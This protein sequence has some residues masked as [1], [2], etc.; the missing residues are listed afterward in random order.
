MASEALKNLVKVIAEAVNTG[1]KQ[2][3]DG[4]QVTDLFALIPI[5]SQIPAVIASKGQIAEE[6]KARTETTLSEILTELKTDLVLI[7]KAL[8]AKIEKAVAL[9]LAGADLYSEFQ[10]KAA[11]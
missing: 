2:L 8:E 7:D 5:A 10:P 9:V 4:F 3:A 11:A 6:W 1:E